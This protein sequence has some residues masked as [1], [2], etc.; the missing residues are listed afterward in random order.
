M[1]A[2]L[3]LEVLQVAVEAEEGL[4]GVRNKWEVPGQG[5]DLRRGKG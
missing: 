3:Q 2:L 4:C 5:R 1:K